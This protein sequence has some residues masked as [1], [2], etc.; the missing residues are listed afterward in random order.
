MS[1]FVHVHRTEHCCSSLHVDQLAR[2]LGQR[3]A[4]EDFESAL[5]PND[6][7]SVERGLKLTQASFENLFLSLIALRETK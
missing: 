3:E 1:V 6:G 7:S 4:H 5:V 2:R